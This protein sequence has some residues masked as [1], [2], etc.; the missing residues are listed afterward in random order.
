MPYSKELVYTFIMM[1]IFSHCTV[2]FNNYS[3]LYIAHSKKLA[4]V[5]VVEIQ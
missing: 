4:C 5:H 2:S 1:L 3:T